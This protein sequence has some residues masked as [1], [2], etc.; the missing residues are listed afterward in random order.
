MYPMRSL[1]QGNHKHTQTLTH[2]CAF[3]EYSFQSTL[4]LFL[5]TCGDTC[6]IKNILREPHS[7]SL[8]ENRSFIPVAGEEAK[9]TDLQKAANLSRTAEK[10]K[11]KKYCNCILIK[12]VEQATV[13]AS[14]IY[15]YRQRTDYNTANFSK[16][17]CL[18]S[19]SSR[20]HQ[21]LLQR[22]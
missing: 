21:L 6:T 10:A 18:N 16:Q 19:I 12:T 1:F 9:V 14:Y 17:T 7:L 3:Q 2:M 11:F 8:Y 15:S 20:V 4:Q 22:S 13:R 5:K